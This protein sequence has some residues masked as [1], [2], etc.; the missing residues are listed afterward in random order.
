LIHKLYYKGKKVEPHTGPSS[1]FHGYGPKIR[2][3]LKKRIPKKKEL[4]VLDVGTGFG[5]IVSFLAKNLPKSARVWTVDPSDEILANVRKKLSEEGL[6]SRIPIDFVQADASKLGFEDN[7]FDVIV[8]AM[9]L[10]HLE[11]LKAVIKELVRVSNKGGKI[12]LADY[13]PRAGRDLEF[14]KRHMESDFFE[15]DH[16]AKTIKNLGVSKVAL[17]KVKLWYLVDITK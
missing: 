1:D 17:K 4:K 13:A 5:T 16:V 3:E 6:D 14:Q 7:Y 8:S 10:H 11:D 12:L 15:P 9:V 2:A